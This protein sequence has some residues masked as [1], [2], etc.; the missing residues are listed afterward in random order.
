[1]F[2]QFLQ[3]AAVFVSLTWGFST[4]AASPAPARVSIKKIDALGLQGIYMSQFVRAK[5]NQD[6]ELSTL[7]RFS[8][9]PSQRRN[10][11]K[12]FRPMGG[13]VRLNTSQVKLMIS[14]IF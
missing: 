12:L 4:L 1:M 8:I 9:Q 11:N 6:K 10:F 3:I 5:S 13:K 14:L 2:S 7:L